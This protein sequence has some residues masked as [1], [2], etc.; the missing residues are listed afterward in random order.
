ME[1]NNNIVTNTTIEKEG[2]K[3]GWGIL[4]FL[5]PIVGLILFLA[6]KNNKKKAA[7]ASGIGALVGFI[8]SLI[9]LILFFAL[10]FGTL[11]GIG[12]AIENYENN[13]TRPTETEPVENTVQEEIA[14][15]D[16]KCIIKATIGEKNYLYNYSYDKSCDVVKVVD[17]DNKVLFKVSNKKTILN[18]GEELD[19]NPSE[20][21]DEGNLL[22]TLTASFYKVDNS[23][24]LANSWCSPGFCYVYVYNTKDNTGFKVKTLEDDQ[25]LVPTPRT[26]E[27]DSNKNL[28]VFIRTNT[29]AGFEGMKEDP[30][31]V[32]LSKISNCEI[33]DID[34]AL[35]ES[36][37]KDFAISE[38]Y[39]YKYSNN[40][41]TNEPTVKVSE[42]IKDYFHG[43]DNICNR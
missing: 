26:I 37:L 34:S 7:K 43:Y 5:L 9:G 27:I 14:T 42:T 24:V 18:N 33:N 25:I 35:S 21:D 41:I 36:S 19:N 29:A 16:G 15:P 2:S 8:L 23:V 17:D 32:L 22:E 13:S 28:V 4:G 38:Y 12:T 40:Q 20:Y 30:R 10:G 1:E 11:I 39:T 31:V 6:W 3:F